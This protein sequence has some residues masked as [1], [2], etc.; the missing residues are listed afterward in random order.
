MSENPG[1][2]AATG[3]PAGQEYE[4]YTNDALFIPIYSHCYF[5]ANSLNGNTLQRKIILKLFP[6]IFQK[7]PTTNHWSSCHPFKNVQYC[8]RFS[9]LITH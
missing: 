9:L 6:V 3:L 4:E 8:Q 7:Y 1:N 5:L 2:A